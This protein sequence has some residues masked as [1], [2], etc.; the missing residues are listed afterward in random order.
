[1][2]S[3]P[4]WTNMSHCIAFFSNH[5]RCL[6]RWI[7]KFEVASAGGILVNFLFL[8]CTQRF[9]FYTHRMPHCQSVAEPHCILQHRVCEG[10]DGEAA[11]C[12]ARPPQGRRPWFR[13]G[14]AP[15]SGSWPPKRTKQ[16]SQ[17]LSTR[18]K[19]R[20]GI[21]SPSSQSIL[22]WYNKTAFHLVEISP[23]NYLCVVLFTPRFL[24]Q[25]V[26]IR[27]PLQNIREKYQQHDRP[28]E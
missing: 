15:S 6:C 26:L 3:K 9:V 2:I 14:A 24:R 4:N 16:L 21:F 27:F 23:V 28:S 8:R 25:T 12:C 1:M 5:I 20:F 22:K 17:K 13:R 7:F 18:R 10:A 19:F 11:R